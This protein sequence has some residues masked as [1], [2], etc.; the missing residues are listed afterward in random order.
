MPGSCPCPVFNARGCG[1]DAAP[2]AW[3]RGDPQGTAERP[4]CPRQL[5][6]YA[7][8][9]GH[10]KCSPRSAP[11][12]PQLRNGPLASGR[13][14]CCEGARLSTGSRPRGPLCRR[15]SDGTILPAAVVSVHGS[16]LSKAVSVDNIRSRRWLIILETN[17]T[18]KP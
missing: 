1:T 5:S 14:T 11:E 17:V 8:R 6:L 10:P 18:P 16:L 3:V 2:G 12:T 7:P 4:C 13:D 15:R 9:P